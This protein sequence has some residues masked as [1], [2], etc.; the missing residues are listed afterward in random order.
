MLEMNASDG[1]VPH[2]SLV[3]PSYNGEHRLAGRLDELK[4]FLVAQP[5]SSEL[6]LVDDGSAEGAARIMRDF[7]AENPCVTVLRNDPNR[8]KGA[9][10]ARGMLAARGRYRVFTDADLAFPLSEVNKIL[11]NLEAGAD[12][13]IACRVLP[14][15]RYL[16]SP[17]FFHYLYTRHLMSRAFNKVVQTF[18]LPGI[19]DT[20][21][22][23]K[24]FTAE[25]AKLCFERTTIPGFG[26]DIECL[27]IAQQHRLSIK[28]TAVN[29]RYDDEP[30]TVRFARD[31]N[32]MLQ[33]IWKVKT[34]ALRGQYAAASNTF[35]FPA[36]DHAV[37]GVHTP[38]HGVPAPLGE[39]AAAS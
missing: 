36:D 19:L 32:R 28:Q 31:S 5:Y 12:V 30:T 9:S 17:S 2:L 8:G 10:V 38:A 21:A 24:G 14:E 22:G 7:A 34:N 4:T 39:M 3:V 6:I 18:L 23:L 35:A 27:Y 26:F 33:D 16:M 1:D 37:P 15:S 29:F 20:Q 13:A 11:R 25:A